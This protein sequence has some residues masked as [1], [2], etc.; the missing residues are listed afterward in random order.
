MA[1]NLEKSCVISEDCSELSKLREE[2]YYLKDKID[3][4]EGN[5]TRTRCP[6]C[7]DFMISLPSMNIRKCSNGHTLEWSLKPGQKSVLI[8]GVIG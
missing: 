5:K 2:N 7:S 6:V 4:L 1:G 3:T 8:E